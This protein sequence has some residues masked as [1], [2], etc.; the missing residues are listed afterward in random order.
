MRCAERM[1][2]VVAAGF[3]V[4]LLALLG[5]QSAMAGTPGEIDLRERVFFDRDA[6]PGFGAARIVPPPETRMPAD[7]LRAATAG[8][9]VRGRV[10]VL[11]ALTPPKDGPMLDTGLPPWAGPRP[12]PWASGP[13]VPTPLSGPSPEIERNERRLV[14]TAPPPILSEPPLPCATAHPRRGVGRA[15]SQSPWADCDDHGMSRLPG[16]P[17]ISS[18]A[19][20]PIVAL[21]F[22]EERPERWGMKNRTPQRRIAA[23]APAFI[24]PFANG[25]V[26]SLFN[27]GR[28]HPAIDLAGALDTEVL[29]TTMRQTVVF[30]GWK[31]GYG[32]LVMA[33]DPSGRLHLYGHLRSITARVGQMLDQGE[34]LGRLGSTGRSTGPHV[35]YEVR[36][37]KGG[38]FNPVKLLFPGRTVRKGFAWADVRLAPAPTTVA[39]NEN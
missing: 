18:H 39:S 37:G 36:D 10:T 14:P 17:K 15:I 3:V 38:H 16:A 30:A 29:A 13:A 1:S 19:G 7:A 6:L 11:A 31:G 32:K 24:M 5:G 27:D 9:A 12:L 34:R 33:R 20:D 23:P 35:H 26:T 4:I 28:R 8:A 22:E 2:R 21:A 25:R